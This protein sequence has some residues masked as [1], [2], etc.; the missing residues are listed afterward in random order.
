MFWIITT[1]NQAGGTQV[2]DDIV[3]RLRAVPLKGNGM[4]CGSNSTIPNPYYNRCQDAANEIELLRAERDKWFHL[5]RRFYDQYGKQG[6]EVLAEAYLLM[7]Y[8]KG[9]PQS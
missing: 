2:T 5:A 1:A 8:E 7:E 4:C 3:T 6:S 9:Y